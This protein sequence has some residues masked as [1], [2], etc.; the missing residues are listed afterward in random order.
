MSAD[1][2]GGGGSEGGTPVNRPPR[3][4]ASSPRKRNFVT[5]YICG[6][7]FTTASLPIHEPQCLDK[8]KLQNA[9]L[10]KEQRRP[11][12]K[13]PPGLSGRGGSYN[14]DEMNEFARQ[15]AASQL[16][17]C[18]NCGRTFD[19][20]RI[21]VHERVCLKGGPPKTPKGRQGPLT[22]GGPVAHGYGS[23]TETAIDEVPP[24]PRPVKQARV[25]KFVFC[26]LCSG[27]FTDASLPIHE[28]QCLQKWEI[29]N[30]QLPPEQ[31]RARPVK[32]QPQ[33][34]TASGSYDSRSV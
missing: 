34:T 25:P 11:L 28:P 31:R 21:A 22:P 16:V 7:E 6:R 14:V 9:Q 29:Q 30:A 4:S 2:S 12:P 10:P 26:Y 20:D 27:K 13:R 8:W 24:K 15:S 18:R 17:P 1:G 32:P 5:C 23:P 33:V 19:P 3:K